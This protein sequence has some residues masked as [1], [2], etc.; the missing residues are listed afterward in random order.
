[1]PG[2]R[3]RAHLPEKRP[4]GGRRL[5]G[6]KAFVREV[7]EVLFANLSLCRLTSPIVQL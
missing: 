6:L 7:R 3:A 5:A 4:T 1:M 2:K